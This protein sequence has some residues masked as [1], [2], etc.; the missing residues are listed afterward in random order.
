MIIVKTKKGILECS[1]AEF[2]K[3]MIEKSTFR[4][5]SLMKDNKR[6]R[7]YGVDDDI[8]FNDVIDH[9]DFSNLIVLNVEK[10]IELIAKG[11]LNT[12]ENFQLFKVRKNQRDS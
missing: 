6:I 11:T 8:S 12:K 4:E 10:L 5:A 3:V 7:W 1:K 2:S 9:Y